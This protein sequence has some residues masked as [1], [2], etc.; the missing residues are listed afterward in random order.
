M[1][2]CGATF[3]TRQTEYIRNKGHQI[4]YGYE[5]FSWEEKLGQALVLKSKSITILLQS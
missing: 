1:Q 3:A 2:I 4:R 5:G